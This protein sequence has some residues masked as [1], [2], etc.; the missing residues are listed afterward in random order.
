[1]NVSAK[2][3]EFLD[4]LF[5][6]GMSVIKKRKYNLDSVQRDFTTGK[7]DYNKKGMDIAIERIHQP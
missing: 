5:T 4:A 1:M 3:A 2:R 7:R 6:A